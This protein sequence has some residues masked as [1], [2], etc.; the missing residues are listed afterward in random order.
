MSKINLQQSAVQIREARLGS[1]TGFQGSAAELV[2]C[3]RGGRLK[4]SAR[5][6]SQ[7][8]GC[9]SSTA[10]CQLSMIQDAAVIN[11][12]P[13]GCSGDFPMFSFVN[14][15][16]QAERKLPVVPGRYF[17]T[18]L[19]EN[20]T[21]F[22]GTPRLEATIREVFERVK[23]KAIFITTSCASGIIGDDVVSVANDLSE[24]LGIPVVVCHCEGFKSK[25]WSTGFDAA[26][27]AVVRTIVKPPRQKT[28]IVNIVNFFGSHVF[29]GLLERLGY[30]ARYILPYTTISQLESLSEAAATLQICPTLGT[31]MGAALEQVYGV[32]EIKAPAAYGIA[33]T[34]LWMRALGRILDRKEEV[35]EIIR[36]EHR[37]VIPRLEEYR[38]KLRGKTAYLTAG[39]AHG[40]AII[41]LLRELG[42]EV[43]GAA[44]FHHDPIY[45]NGETSTDILEHVVNTYGDLPAYNVCNKQTYELV[46]I[47]NRV[48]PDI[49]VARHGGMV[50]WGARLGIPTFL[51]EDEQF[52]F[53]YQGVLNYAEKILETLDNVEFTN[54]LARHSTIPYTRWW[55]EQDPFTFLE[56][57][58][59]GDLY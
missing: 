37:R 25:V 54:N 5:S 56:E 52:G 1:I 48:K 40:H 20:D 30:K 11:H 15:V 27:H 2:Q 45:D 3:S 6:F 33:G 38:D 41:A 22:G 55:L 29:D 26:F 14:R 13:V 47:L 32:P 10:F 43:K 12:A 8:L 19:G 50:I 28:N 44:I 53:G 24:E 58:V 59:D 39:A 36:E 18:N 31:Y 4:D 21:V 34:D 17:S 49:L 7:C 9:S 35:E 42:I 16:G 46:N 23:P 51:M 57:G